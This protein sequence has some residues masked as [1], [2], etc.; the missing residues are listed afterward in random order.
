MVCPHCG[1]ENPDYVFYCGS[2]GESVREPAGPAGE[3]GGEVESVPAEAA[4]VADAPSHGVSGRSTTSTLTMA[5]VAVAIGVVLLIIGFI[6]SVYYYERMISPNRGF[7]EMLSLQDIVKFSMYTRMFGEIS[8]LIGVVLVVQSL[9]RGGLS[10]ASVLA[11]RAGLAKVLWLAIVMI[12]LIGIAAVTL[13]VIYEAE[14]DLGEDVSRVIVR[15]YMYL[16]IL[17]LVL[18]ATALLLVTNALRRVSVEAE[19]GAF[20]VS[21]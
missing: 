8:V 5:T 9:M 17:A 10:S 3:P 18:G 20:A 14:P 19:S 21:P 16:P 6:L 15:V 12:V 13:V 7:D 1:A 11:K 2:C 4:Y